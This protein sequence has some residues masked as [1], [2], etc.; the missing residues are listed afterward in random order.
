MQITLLC[1]YLE[2]GEG[3]RAFRLHFQRSR[4][5]LRRELASYFEI[6][7]S[8]PSY[9]HSSTPGKLIKLRLHQ[10]F[11]NGLECAIHK[12]TSV[13]ADDSSLPLLR[14][15]SPFIFPFLLRA[16]LTIFFYLFW[17]LQFLYFSSFHLIFSFLR[18]LFIYLSLIFL[19]LLQIVYFFVD[20][21]YFCLFFLFVSLFLFVLQFFHPSLFFV[22][23][24]LLFSSP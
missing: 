24:F 14:F 20:S 17:F 5:K 11:N 9:S 16:F 7:S 19:I 15:L 12:F 10:Y 4:K 23:F 8:A 6:A 2:H 3:R 1:T 21:L 22:S 13:S 18:D